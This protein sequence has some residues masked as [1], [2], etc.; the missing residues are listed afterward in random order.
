MRFRP[1]V[2]LTTTLLVL[3]MGLFY[4]TEAKTVDAGHATASWKGK[5][6]IED[7]G[8]GDRVFSG[9]LTGTILV[10]HLPEGSAPVQFHL[11]NMDCQAILY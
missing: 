3:S 7:L 8:D 2:I 5:G 11:T 1:S 10:K 6:V 4:N 9:R